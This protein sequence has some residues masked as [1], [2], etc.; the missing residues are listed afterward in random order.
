VLI[1]IQLKQ[2][3]VGDMVMTELKKDLAMAKK[4]KKGVKT[5]K[6]VKSL[7]RKYTSNAK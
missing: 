2:R 5:V 6:K 3:G 1:W 4:V 7:R